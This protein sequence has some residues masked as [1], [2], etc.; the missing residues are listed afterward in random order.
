VFI[1]GALG[2]GGAGYADGMAMGS[3]LGAQA[4]GVVAVAA[5]SAVATAAL[6]WLV[7]IVFPMRVSQEDERQGL[8]VASHGDRGWAFD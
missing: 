7:S 6:A 2:Y 8:D 3:M 5:W 4:L 1:S